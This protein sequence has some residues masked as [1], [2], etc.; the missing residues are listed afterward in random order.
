MLG[1]EKPLRVERLIALLGIVYGKNSGSKQA[2]WKSSVPCVQATHAKRRHQTRRDESGA[3]HEP[4]RL[5]QCSQQAAAP[6]ITSLCS[7][8]SGA[9]EIP[10]RAQ[11]N[12]TPYISGSPIPK[13]LLF[14]FSSPSQ[15]RGFTCIS[16]DSS[17]ITFLLVENYNL[18]ALDQLRK[19]WLR[20]FWSPSQSRS[21][22]IDFSLFHCQHSHE[23]C[24]EEGLPSP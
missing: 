4:A 18:T 21:S 9:R 12:H 10:T 24:G 2:A 23:E 5:G 7:D 19:D 13:F 17:E 1:V 16:E 11:T 14:F 22:S 6:P 3:S 20:N 8:Q 15:C